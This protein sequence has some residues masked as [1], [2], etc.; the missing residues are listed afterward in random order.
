M[1]VYLKKL[2]KIIV[3]FKQKKL[4]LL[5]KGLKNVQKT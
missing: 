1:E 4:T 5:L 3:V 2:M